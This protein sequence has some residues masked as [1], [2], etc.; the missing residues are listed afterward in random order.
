MLSRIAESLYWIGRYVE[1]AEDTARILD[2]HIHHLLE[3]PWVD[4]EPA[5]RALLGGHGRRR[6]T[7]G[8]AR[9][10]R[11]T[12]LLAF[13]AARPELDRRRARGGPGERPRRPRGHLVGD[14]GVPQRHL[15]RPARPDVGPGRRRRPARLLPL[16]QGAGR[17]PRRPGRL[18]HEPR[19]RLALPG[20]RPQPRAGR[21]DGPAAA[22]PRFSDG[23][24]LARLGHDAALLLGP[25]G[26]PAHLPPRGRAVT[27]PPSSCC[28]TGSSRARSSTPCARPSSAWPSSSPT[29]AG[30]ALDDEARRILGRA[31]T[32]LEFRRVDE[33]LADLPAAPR[34]RSRPP[35]PT[36]GDRRRPPL[37]PPDRT[38]SSG[39][40]EVSL[41][42]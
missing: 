42:L 31:R 7:A 17:H 18:D 19:R 8:R 23:V 28:S 40:C 24:G 13:D 10:R 36:A 25:R 16:R 35:A 29:P 9:R 6:P 38:P 39:A 33:L 41:G 11:V 3:D 20:A 32:D 14:V 26:L 37:L 12:E 15:Q 1:R 2:V 5:C 4:E 34:A 27:W 22:R 21:H 30:P